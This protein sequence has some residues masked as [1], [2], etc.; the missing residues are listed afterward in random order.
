MQREMLSRDIFQHNYPSRKVNILGY[1][2]NYK[3]LRGI[4]KCL[5]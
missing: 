5:N 2:Y 3:E 4:N 1:F